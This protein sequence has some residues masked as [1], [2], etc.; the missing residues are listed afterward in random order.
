MYHHRIVLFNNEV[1]K[2]DP[3]TYFFI[4]KCDKLPYNYPLNLKLSLLSLYVKIKNTHNTV[5][6]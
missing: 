3:K 6:R 1:D 4:T 5:E 2:K